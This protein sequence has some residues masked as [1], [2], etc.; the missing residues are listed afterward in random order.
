MEKRRKQRWDK[1]KIFLEKIMVSWFE[2]CFLYEQDVVLKN[3]KNNQEAI[4][5]DLLCSVFQYII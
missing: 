4:C 1:L 5:K 2:S 3:D